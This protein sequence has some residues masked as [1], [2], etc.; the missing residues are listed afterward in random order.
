LLLLTP[1]SKINTVENNELLIEGNIQLISSDTVNIEFAWVDKKELIQLSN[2]P[3]NG[4]YMNL[5]SQTCFEIFMQPIGNEKYY[6]FN[7][8]AAKAWNVFAFDKYREPQ[9][10]TEYPQ[11]DLLKFD[12]S[13]NS[14][15]VQFRLAGLDLKKVKV[16]ICAVIVL[17]DIG[18]TYWSTKHADTKPNF[19]HFDSFFIE[20]NAP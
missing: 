7:L 18:T 1:F 12:V 17:K 9:P 15:K 2:A 4:R 13:S 20:R 11:T 14:L 3:A 8:S 6:E 5:W 19:H 10:P 16:S